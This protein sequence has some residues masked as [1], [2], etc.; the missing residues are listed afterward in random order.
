V[1][2]GWPIAGGWAGEPA[3]GQGGAGGQGRR[4]QVG[5]LMEERTARRRGGGAARS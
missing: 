5:E 2:V 3:P 4:G 1:W